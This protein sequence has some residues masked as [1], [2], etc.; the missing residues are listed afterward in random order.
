MSIVVT[1][2]TGHVGSRVTE[3]LVQAGAKPR[4]L[5]RDAGRLDAGIAPLVDAR[6]GDMT[7]NA[8]V[9]AALAGTGTVFW[10]DP[11]P[12][13]HPDPIETSLRTA[14]G[15]IGAIE[16]GDV[17]RVVF[18]SSMGA[19]V[20]K[21]VG[22]I[23]AL[24]AIEERL[25]ATGADVTILRCGNFFTNLLG[26]LDDLRSGVLTTSGVPDKPI[27]WVAPRDIGEVAAARLLNPSWTGRHVQGVHGPEDLTWEQVAAISG[28]AI[29]RDVR[30]Q[31]VTDDDV[32]ASLRAAGLPEGAVEGIVGMTAGTRT[33]TFDPPRTTLSTTPTPLTAWARSHLRPAVADGA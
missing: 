16:A 19:E 26:S 24:G 10:L 30:L 18:L 2:P 22:H 3:L 5:V 28:E 8:Y 27:P 13:T 4:V 7:D 6:E 29:G 9:R 25:N 11:T 14:D 15:L 1:T 17:D 21:G 32:R 20:R 23:D 12:H 33:I 31:V